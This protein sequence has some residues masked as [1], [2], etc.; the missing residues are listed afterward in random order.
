MFAAATP[1]SRCWPTLNC[2]VYWFHPV[3]W[4]IRRRLTDLAEQVCDDAVIRVTGS[5]NEYAQNLL[6]IAGRLSAG[7]G[8]SGRFGRLA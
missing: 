7:C 3:A 6:D 1:G 5:R 8:R 2:A 4:F